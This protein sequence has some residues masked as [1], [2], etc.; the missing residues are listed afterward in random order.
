MR[1][2]F[3]TALF[4]YF[5]DRVSKI[6]ILKA[7]GLPW[8]VLPVF[9]IVKTWNPGVVFGIG[10]SL[11]FKTKG[12]ILFLI[13]FLLL[14]VVFIA[15][16]SKSPFEKALLGMIFGGGLGNFTDRVF[17]GKVLDF[18]DFHFKG[19]HW[20]AFNMADVSITLGILLYAF[21]FLRKERT[22]T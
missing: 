20:P 19:L 3:L 7:S 6:W 21:N 5:L 12:A 22:C 4:V 1:V 15:F 9:R 18:L 10:G 17:Y 13:V 14:L 16:K 2:F 11:F 8:D